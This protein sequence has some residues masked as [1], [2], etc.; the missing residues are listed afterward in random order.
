MQSAHDR[1]P[2]SRAVLAGYVLPGDVSLAHAFST[3]FQGLRASGCGLAAA[4]AWLFLAR[5]TSPAAWF[6]TGRLPINWRKHAMRQSKR[7][8]EAEI[9]HCFGKNR[10]ARALKVSDANTI[11]HLNDQQIGCSSSLTIR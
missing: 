11:Q 5:S 2:S 1:T 6:E 7:P 8:P 3:I 9:R 4:N 10:H